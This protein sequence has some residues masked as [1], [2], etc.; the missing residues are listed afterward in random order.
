M[1]R[2]AILILLGAGVS[3]CTPMSPSFIDAPSNPYVGA[4]SP[5]YRSVTGGVKEFQVTDPKDWRELNRQVGPS[6]GA[7]DQGNDAAAA[8]RRGR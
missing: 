3:A 4:R 5:G 7:Q 2:I 8:A 6:D 1:S